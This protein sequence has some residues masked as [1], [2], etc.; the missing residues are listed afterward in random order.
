MNKA[1]DL[2]DL[3]LGYMFNR[4]TKNGVLVEAFRATHSGNIFFA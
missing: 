2:I 4:S 1:V 3:K